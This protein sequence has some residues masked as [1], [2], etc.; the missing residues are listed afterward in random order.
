MRRILALILTL[1]YGAFAMAA[2]P[3]PS[4]ESALF[5]GGCFWCMQPSFD[6]TPGVIAT[7]VGYA[8]GAAN[9]AN[10]EAVSGGTTG[11]VEVIEVQ[12]DPAKV[13]YE[14]LLT[15]YLENI[16]P[17]DG[18][19][20]FAD[21]GT[22]Y[23]PVIFTKNAAQQTAAKKALSDIGPKFAPAAIAVALRDAVPFYAAEDYHQKY[24][25]KK[26]A[27]YDAYKQGSGRAAFIE[28]NWKK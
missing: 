11:H 9:T 14:K 13:S 1:T 2:T 10:Y 16:D 22:Q 24:Y 26:S 27:H 5:G 8:G 3:A 25:Q 15:I 28:K 19:G 4:H 17:T 21:R 6:A 23:A 18:G 20:Q 7:S 12:Y